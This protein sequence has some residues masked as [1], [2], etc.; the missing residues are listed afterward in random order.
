MAI[1]EKKQPYFSKVIHG[2][3]IS[4]KIAG[5]YGMNIAVKAF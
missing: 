1:S 5:L 3:I 2:A 4:T